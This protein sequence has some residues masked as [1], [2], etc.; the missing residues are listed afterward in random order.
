MENLYDRKKCYIPYHYDAVFY[1]IFADYN[2]LDLIKY[3]LENVLDIK[4]KKM[5]IL[6]ECW[7]RLWTKV[8]NLETILK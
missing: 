4:I 7:K 5:E 1:K 2:D 6:K 8:K 3:L